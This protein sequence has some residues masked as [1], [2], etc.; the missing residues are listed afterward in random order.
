M[1]LQE[2][3]KHYMTKENVV[4]M[5]TQYELYYQISLGNYVFETL[6]DIEDTYKKIEELNLTVD[7]N[8]ALS[9]IF[10]V[11]VRFSPQENF[12]EKFNYHLRSRALTHS[13]ADFINNDK[14]LI[15][16]DAYVEQK[17]RLIL[18]DTF[19]TENMKLQLEDEYP[20][21]NESYEMLITDEIIS[22]LQSNLSTGLVS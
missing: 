3:I 7:P 15:G 19:F 14:E 9:N 5:L 13:L 20:I 18:N 11:I 6:Q 8:T 1:N 21:I 2:T 17:T 4:D 12:E 22:K 16:K 10:E